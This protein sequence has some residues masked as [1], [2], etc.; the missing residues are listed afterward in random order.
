LIASLNRDRLVRQRHILQVDQWTGRPVIG[1]DLC[2]EMAASRPCS[3]QI[4]E[5]GTGCSN[6]GGN[7]TAM[8]RKRLSNLSE[9]FVWE[10]KLAS[11][12]PLDPL[13]DCKCKVPVFN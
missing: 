2:Q 12:P 8:R 9:M 5:T 11:V 7:V 3:R 6:T 13:F 1:S 4:D 10:W